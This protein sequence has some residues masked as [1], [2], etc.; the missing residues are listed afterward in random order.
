MINPKSKELAIQRTKAI[1]ALTMVQA[2]F[3]MYKPSDEKLKKYCDEIY[4]SIRECSKNIK[5]KRVSAGAKHALDNCFQA[6]EPYMEI[7]VTKEDAIYKWGA[8]IWCAKTFMEEVIFT[9]KEYLDGENLDGW[10]TFYGLIED[11]AE[12]LCEI[13][14]GMDEYGTM[15]YE[16]GAWALEGKDYTPEEANHYELA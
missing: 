15:I 4:D 9:C 11:F 5:G 3:D 7:D 13:A 12:S 2:C 16:R 14:P 6:L 10:K 8:L 1:M